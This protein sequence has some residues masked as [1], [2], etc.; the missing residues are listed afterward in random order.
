MDIEV[1]VINLKAE[2]CRQPR[3]EQG[4]QGRVFP[5]VKPHYS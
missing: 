2:E 3:K 1:S 4:G 5:G